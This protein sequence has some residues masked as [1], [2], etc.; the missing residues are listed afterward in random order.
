MSAPSSPIKKTVRLISLAAPTSELGVTSASGEFH[1]QEA[2]VADLDVPWEAAYEEYARR[3]GDGHYIEADMTAEVP[4]RR[5]TP[6]PSTEEVALFG[7]PTCAA[8]PQS[9]SAPTG[10]EP[11][12]H[13]GERYSQLALARDHARKNNSLGRRVRIAHI[14][15]G[16]DKS[17][18]ALPPAAQ[19]LRDL[20]R[21]FT[22][23]PAAPFA[24]DPGGQ[25]LPLDN[26][27]HGTATL[28]ILA[29]GPIDLLNRQPL[30]GAPDAEVLPLRISERVVLVGT[31][32]LAK[33]VNYA[34]DSGCD[35]ITLSM[36]GVASKFWVDAYNRAYENGVF[37][38]VRQLGTA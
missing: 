19:I 33:A 24:D 17:H 3:G 32:A 12:W 22:R 21:D 29:G 20:S 5:L 8:K 6:E 14:D 10:P 13:L 30:G 11:G 16:Y 9:H 36:G 34:I 1:V 27:G 18:G 15:T 37:C 28:C 23:H 7:R 38:V 25:G 35:V 26:R 31:D 4:F 2:A